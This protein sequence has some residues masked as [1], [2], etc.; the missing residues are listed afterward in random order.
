MMTLLLVI[1]VAALLAAL[2]IGVLAAW[3]DLRGMTIPNLHSALVLAAFPISCGA[4]WLA[5]ADVFGSVL[6]HA[7][8]FGIVFG[9]T[10][11]L[12]ALKVMGGADS[13]LASAYGVWVGLPGLAPFLFYMALAGGILAV[14]ALLIR[15][16]KPFKAPAKESWAG[17][18]QNDAS[19]VPYGVAIVFGAFVSFWFLGYLDMDTFAAFLPSSS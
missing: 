12:F 17:Q 14:A 7:L 15:H 2:G 3:S 5:G 8:G 16:F 18:L 4:A 11:G 9:L 1:Y 19:K 6:S 10:L 13:K